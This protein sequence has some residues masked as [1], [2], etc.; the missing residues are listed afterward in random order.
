MIMTKLVSVSVCAFG[1]IVI[2]GCAMQEKKE[3]AA[4]QAMPVKCATA[5]GD[6]RVL[7]REGLHCS[8]GR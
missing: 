8:K 2:S 3:L 1:I 4:A 5:P 7:N 6:L